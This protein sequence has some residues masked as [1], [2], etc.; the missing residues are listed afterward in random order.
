MQVLFCCC[1]CVLSSARIAIAVN[2]VLKTLDTMACDM[3]ML[4]SGKGSEH[5][6]A[7]AKHL[8]VPT[9]SM[10]NRTSWEQKQS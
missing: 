4:R 7:L 8:G 3:I 1:M 9:D 5:D 2:L 6:A 10:Q